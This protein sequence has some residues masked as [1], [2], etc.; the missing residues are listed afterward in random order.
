MR[1]Y[2]LIHGGHHTKWCWDRLIP[3]L[4]TL[5]HSAVA[6]DLPGRGA[7]AD[8]LT[9]ASLDDCVTAIGEAVD[10]FA[11][12]PTLV[13]H[14][15]GGV[16]TTQYAE[17]RPET[18]AGVVYVCAVVPAAGT[19]GLD[20]LAEAGPDSA[21]LGDGVFSFFEDRAAAR[22]DPD[23]ATKAFY[24]H[25]PED[26]IEEAV[27]RLVPEA[28]APL[29]TPLQ[30]GAAFASVPKHYI[31]ATHDRAVPLAQQTRMAKRA[32]AT[33]DC[34]NADHSPFLSAADELAAKLH[35]DAGRT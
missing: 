6:I 3:H 12:A 19:S 27:S 10:G 20:T 22:I 4:E 5:G 24:G 16:S 9:A 28:V 29:A 1:E 2:L 30:L 13:A 8:R 25:C 18:I 21:L 15:M 35:E 32:G 26:V 33:F 17:E 11:T 34:L 31:G 23:A 7:T 14:S